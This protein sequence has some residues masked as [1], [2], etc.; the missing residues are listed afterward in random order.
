[1][2]LPK[3]VT[4]VY[5]TTIP[6]TDQKIKFKPFLIK[7]H[8][9]LL[10]AQQSEDQKVMV[11]TLKEVARS[12]IMD[13]VDIDSL[14]IFD[15]QYLLLQIRAKSVGEMVDLIF[16]CDTCIDDKAKVKINFDL[17]KMEVTKNPEHNK[18]I[19]LYDETGMVLKYPNLDNITAFDRLDPDDIG[20]I[21]NLI[22]D[23]ID[24]IYQ[25]N[26]TYYAKEQTREDLTE[27][28][29]NL[30]S[31]QFASIVKFYE[32]MPRLR[33]AVKYR[34]P[35]CMKEHNKYIEGIETFF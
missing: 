18:K 17:T 12:C 20:G 19:K 8:K 29:D 2:A 23:S 24:Y 25:G 28:L 1:M 21:F 9:A 27:F 14:A 30:T 3:Q 34:C 22:I 7:E 31:D 4:T 33:Q 10:M 16:S 35:V 15:L 6:S 11:D 5:N 32:T 13:K 26:E